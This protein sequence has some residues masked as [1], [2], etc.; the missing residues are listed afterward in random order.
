[1]Y[2]CIYLYASYICIHFNISILIVLGLL[3]GWFARVMSVIQKTV[4][5]TCSTVTISGSY[6]NS[7]LT[8]VSPTAI[9]KL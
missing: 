5:F 1:M 2:V 4:Y 7:Y 3:T 6:K 9:K 8:I